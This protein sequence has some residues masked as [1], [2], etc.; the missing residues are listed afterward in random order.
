MTKNMYINQN[1]KRIL[2]H[3]NGEANI[4]TIMKRTDSTY[5]CIHNKLNSMQK[6]KLIIFIDTDNKRIRIP[7]LTHM[8][9]QI[10]DFILIIEQNVRGK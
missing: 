3:I 4:S 6:Q 9:E 5:M 10:R 8:G 1:T 2:L 7:K